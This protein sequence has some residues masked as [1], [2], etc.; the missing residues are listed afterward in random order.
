[1]SINMITKSVTQMELLNNKARE[2]G[3]KIEKI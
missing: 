1:M 3:K 2:E